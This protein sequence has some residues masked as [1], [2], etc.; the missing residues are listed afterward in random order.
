METL[1]QT[2]VKNSVIDVQRHLL[3]NYPPQYGAPRPP[4]KLLWWRD[5][6]VYLALL[7]GLLGSPRRQAIIALLGTLFFYYLSGY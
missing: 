7:T 1:G 4:T 2:L 3:D 5:L 6:S